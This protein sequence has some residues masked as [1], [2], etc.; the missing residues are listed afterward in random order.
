MHKPI[1]TSLFA[2]AL[3]ASAVAGAAAVNLTR[4]T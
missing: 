4:D 1:T 2:I 3:L